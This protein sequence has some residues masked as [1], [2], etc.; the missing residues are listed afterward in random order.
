MKRSH[1]LL[2]GDIVLPVLLASLQ[3]VCEASSVGLNPLA[4]SM[5]TTGPTGNLSVNNFGAAGGLAVAAGDLS[6]GAFQTVL[7]FDLADARN[8]FDVEFGFGQWTVQSVTLQLTSTPNN[9]PSFFN[10]AAAGL[11]NVSWL[12]NNMWIEGTGTPNSPTTDG[13]SYESLQSTF[14]DNATDENLGTFS[15]LGGS[16]G[17]S[18]YSLALTSGLLA[19]ILAGD[20]ISLRLYA[21]DDVVSYL[22]NSRSV[23]NSGSRPALIVIA[24]PEPRIVTVAVFGLIALLLHRLGRT[25]SSR[26]KLPETRRE[27]P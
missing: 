22:F 20:H 24:V 23:P 15:F 6:N 4:D 25:C 13:I 10:S 3:C 26:F 2:A 14:I 9:N 18:G 21:A 8:S 19:D 12:K 5:T 27:R 7:R 1:H 16:A 17:V 11:F